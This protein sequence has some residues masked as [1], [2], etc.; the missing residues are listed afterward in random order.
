MF[1][2]TKIHLAEENMTKANST[3]KQ[4]CLVQLRVPKKVKVFLN[5]VNE[6]KKYF[7]C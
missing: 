4:S 7:H 1:V 6:N 5:I 2:A 3:K